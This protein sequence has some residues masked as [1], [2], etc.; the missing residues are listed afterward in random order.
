MQQLQFE[1]SPLFILVCVTAGL[2]YAFILYR[3]KN[4]WSKRTNQLLFAL[5][6]GAVALLC[7]LLIGPIVKLTVNQVEKPTHVFLIDNSTSIRE[8]LDSVKRQQLEV[9]LTQMAEVLVQQGFDVQWRNLSGDANNNFKFTNTQSDISS[10]LRQ[11]MAEFEG[12]NLAGVTLASD[13][14][15]NSGTSPLYTPINV[16]VS[17]I[18]IGDTALRADLVLKNIAYNKIAYQGNKFPVRAEV[19]AQNLANENVSVTI[20]KNGKI[21]D[22][23]TKNTGNLSSLDVDFLLDATEKGTQRLDVAVAPLRKETNLKNNRASIFIDVVEG[24]KKILLVAPAPHPDIKAIRAVVEKNSNYEFHLHI[25]AISEAPADVL[26]PGA[27]ELVIFH[28]VLDAGNRTAA[29]FQSLLKSKI[30]LLVMVGS[31][32]NLRQLQ[33]NGIALSFESAGQFDEVTPLVNSDFR[34]FTFPENTN[35]IISRYPPAEVPFGKFSYPPQASILLYQRIGNVAT[36]RPMLMTWT[37]E[38]RK[39]AALVGEGIWRW[40][41][42][43]FMATEKTE[44]FDDVFLKLIQYLTTLDDKRKFRFFPIQNEF[45]ESQSVTFESQVYNDLFERVYGNKIDIELK[46]EQGKSSHYDYVTSAAGA[47]YQI[48]GLKE[49]VYRYSAKTNVGTKPEQVQGQFLVTAANIEAQSLTADFGLLRKLSK[50]TGGKF[51][52]TSDFAKLSQDFQKLEAKG[53]IHTDESFNPLINLKWFFFLLV[54]LLSAE[55][56]LRKY[57]GGY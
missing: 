51:Y 20:S 29:L 32:S 21:I 37:D 22:Q 49:G 1:Y 14:I 35:G 13:G 43:E 9:G 50:N 24:K 19:I 18:G 41:L 2:G 54:L 40:R 28:Q 23:Q 27:T 38:N 10:A 8:V 42:Q 6:A 44:V 3:S 52:T 55:W 46:D 12:K 7:F 48:G 47:R 45:I 34:D 53:L 17:T 36:T 39:I 30:S 5:R 26:K 11:T 56:F 33:P 16:P 25:P 4:H 31:Q 15:Y 57:N